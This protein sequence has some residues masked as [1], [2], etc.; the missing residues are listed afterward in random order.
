MRGYSEDK[1]GEWP[2]HI[3]ITWQCGKNRDTYL[4]SNVVSYLIMSGDI[5]QPGTAVPDDHGSDLP[6]QQLNSLW[7]P[8]G[9]TDGQIGGGG[10]TTSGSLPIHALPPSTVCRRTGS[11]HERM[12]PT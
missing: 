4:L 1:R 8:S 9:G 6:Y 2:A 10:L 11:G 12:M 3:P 5:A 7:L